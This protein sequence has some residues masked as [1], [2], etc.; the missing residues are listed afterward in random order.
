MQTKNGKERDVEKGKAWQ[1]RDTESTALD[2][3]SW[4][5]WFLLAGTAVITTIGLA[6][7]IPP[8]LSE[9]SMHLWPWAETDVV[10]LVG[11]SLVVVTFV[12]YLTQQQRQVTAMRKEMLSMKDISNERASRHNTHLIALL[13]VSR[14]MGSET[15]PKTVFDCITSVCK[16]T[17]EC[18]RASLMLIDKESTELVVR[19]ASGHADLSMILGA[20]QKIGEGISGWVAKQRKPILFRQN[21]AGD[22][23]DL[24]FASRFIGSAMVVPIIV[25]EELVG[26]INVSTL[27]PGSEYD[28]EDLRSLEVFAENAGTCIRHTEQS[29][30]MRKTINKLQHSIDL[31]RD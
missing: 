22:Y 4:R 5:N 9:N 12:G 13:N 15:N 30:W 23:P 3:H 8:L 6:T 28:D 27:S 17:F 24:E 7:A 2:H 19:A 10:L 11:L 21:C 18:D 16:E 14:L 25:R 26:V 29:D 20:R 1:T 31:E